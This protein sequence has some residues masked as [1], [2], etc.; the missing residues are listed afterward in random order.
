MGT[1][2]Q[3]FEIIQFQLKNVFQLCR[4][5]PGIVQNCSNG[6]TEYSPGLY[7]N[8]TGVVHDNGPG[9]IV[10]PKLSGVGP[11]VYQNTSHSCPCIFIVPTSSQ[12]KREGYNNRSR[13][14]KFNN[15]RTLFKL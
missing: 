11:S 4:F 9:D 5:V 3:I 2:G 10:V 6:C 8:F 13:N 7:Q 1:A 12:N 14:R 15:K